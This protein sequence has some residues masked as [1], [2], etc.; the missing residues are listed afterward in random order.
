LAWC[1]YGSPDELPN[2]H[3]RKDY[4]ANRTEALPDYRVTCSFVD[5]DYRQ[6]GAAGV[7]LRGAVDL[8]AKASVDATDDVHELLQVDRAGCAAARVAAT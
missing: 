4:E 3:H 2:I 5:R 6:K 1:Q 7:A 8:I